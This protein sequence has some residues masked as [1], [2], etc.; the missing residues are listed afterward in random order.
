[1]GI[2]VKA[3]LFLSSNIL[4]LKMNWILFLPILNTVRLRLGIQYP[5]TKFSKVV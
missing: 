1:V 5:A 4:P 2:R 3:K